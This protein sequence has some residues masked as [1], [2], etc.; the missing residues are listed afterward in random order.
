VKSH[1]YDRVASAALIVAALI[2]DTHGAL[3]QTTSNAGGVC[4][5]LATRVS[6]V[7]A[8][9]ATAMV[10]LAPGGPLVAGDADS[11][12]ETLAENR[13]CSD[14]DPYGDTRGLLSPFRLL[15]R[16]PAL[17]DTRALS[18]ASQRHGL[19]V[20]ARANARV[21]PDGA[22]ALGYEVAF[23]AWRNAGRFSFT[24]YV[25]DVESASMQANL[26]PSSTGTGPSPCD[27][28]C[29]VNGTAYSNGSSGARRL[30]T[31]ARARE[32][33]LTT[34]GRWST[35][36]LSLSAGAGLSD[37][38]G[39]RR[40]ALGE[41]ALP[42]STR[43]EVVAL[44]RTSSRS[45]SPSGRAIGAML[46]YHIGRVSSTSRPA[47]PTPLP[48]RV[49]PAEREH[50]YRLIVQAGNASTVR[51]RADFTSWE[52][53]SLDATSGDEWSIVLPVDAGVH[54]VLVSIDDGDWKAPAGLPAAP[55][56]FGQ[57]VG[58]LRIGS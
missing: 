57:T 52:V 2:G 20:R 31:I 35:L 18:Q 29:V 53:R 11:R 41:I 6:S 54:Q 38:A 51:L 5:R 45:V 10:A 43:V 26:I 44:A 55:D 19:F 7:F 48:F 49:E 1:G 39:P 16:A 3:A 21:A 15:T 27:T 14:A 25:Q 33:V 32:L 40:W 56:D 58:V 47:S 34:S 4:D 37:V 24:T 8:S 30:A 22:H 36:A 28:D 9:T 46:R 42:V 17:D 23:G 12:L 13:R 50:T